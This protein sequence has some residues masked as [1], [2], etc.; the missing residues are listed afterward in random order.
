MQH[1]RC[2]MLDQMEA[3]QRLS[4]VCS[5]EELA[6]E[7]WKVGN[8]TREKVGAVREGGLG[9]WLYDQIL[10]FDFAGHYRIKCKEHANVASNALAAPE[11]S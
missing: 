10:G 7:E 2:D 11:F 5:G 3:M 8:M 9:P 6:V 4:K 1:N